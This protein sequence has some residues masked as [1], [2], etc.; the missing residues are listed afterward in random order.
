MKVGGLY[1]V[2]NPTSE[3]FEKVGVLRSVVSY[4]D[5]LEIPSPKRPLWIE[6]IVWSGLPSPS[7]PSRFCSTTWHRNESEGHPLRRLVWIA[8]RAR[9]LAFRLDGCPCGHARYDERTDKAALCRVPGPA[10]SGLGASRR[11]IT[12]DLKIRKKLDRAALL[13]QYEIEVG[14]PGQ[15]KWATEDVIRKIRQYRF[16]VW[17]VRVNRA[18]RP[19]FCVGGPKQHRFGP[20]RASTGQQ[21]VSDS[22]SSG[23]VTRSGSVRSFHA[24]WSRFESGDS[25]CDALGLAQIKSLASSFTDS[26]QHVHLATLGFP[27]EGKR[28]V[29]R[30]NPDARSQH[31][32]YRVTDP[33]SGE[34]A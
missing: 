7:H 20:V 32:D 33:S 24:S 5:G 17:P 8:T 19:S 30:W 1:K 22:R 13:R 29:S 23:A 27:S 11:V 18:S 4:A 31:K 10:L 6:F 15:A 2:T 9:D 21:A 34:S 16:K 3:H 12:G 28:S 26:Y 25:F 14:K